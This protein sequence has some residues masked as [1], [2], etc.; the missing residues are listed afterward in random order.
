VSAIASGELGDYRDRVLEQRRHASCGW[1]RV[2][3]RV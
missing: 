1:P 3:A 2:R